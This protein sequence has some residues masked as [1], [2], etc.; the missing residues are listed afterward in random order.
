MKLNILFCCFSILN[1]H[2]E[3]KHKIDEK[4]GEHLKLEGSRRLVGDKRQVPQVLVLAYA[5]FTP[6]N[7]VN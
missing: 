3:T 2:N 5:F 7:I 6:L 1:T 4:T